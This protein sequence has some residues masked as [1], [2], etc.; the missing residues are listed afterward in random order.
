MLEER[1]DKMNRES[2]RGC[3]TFI[4]LTVASLTLLYVLSLWTDRTLDFWATYFAQHAVDIPMWLS[5]LLTFIG[6]GIIFGLNVIS[7]IV[8]IAMGV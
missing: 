6:N 2:N 7:E 3:I 5:I 1:K 8:R 4:L